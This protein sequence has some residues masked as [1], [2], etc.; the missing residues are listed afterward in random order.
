MHGKDIGQTEFLN[1][2]FKNAFIRTEKDQLVAVCEI[3]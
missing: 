2:L 3:V 1:G